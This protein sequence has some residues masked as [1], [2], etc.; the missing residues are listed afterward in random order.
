ML[1]YNKECVICGRFY[2]PIRHSQITCGDKECQ[3]EYANLHFKRKYIS[4]KKKNNQLMLGLTKDAIAARNN[5]LTY[6]QYKG[7]EWCRNK[8]TMKNIIE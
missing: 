8:Q 1:L 7:R 6:G 3:R 2:K 4:K 5:G